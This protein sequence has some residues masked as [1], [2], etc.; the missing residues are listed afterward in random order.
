MTPLIKHGTYEVRYELLT[1]NN[2]DVPSR[3]NPM[4][5]MPNGVEK[6]GLSKSDATVEKKRVVF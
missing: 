3:V 2:G 5:F 1:G 6:V 4:D